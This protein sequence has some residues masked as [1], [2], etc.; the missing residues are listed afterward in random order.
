LRFLELSGEPLLQRRY[1]AVA[2]PFTSAQQ[3]HGQLEGTAHAFDQVQLVDRLIE[4]LSATA[5]S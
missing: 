1:A 5:F 2:A 3:V 4:K